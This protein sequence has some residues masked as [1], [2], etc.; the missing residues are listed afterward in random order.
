[1]K[2]GVELLLLS[3]GPQVERVASYIAAAAQNGELP[4][5]TLRA[6]AAKVRALA[7]DVALS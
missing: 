6:T 7:N 1:L 5:S 2:A 4:I 3:S